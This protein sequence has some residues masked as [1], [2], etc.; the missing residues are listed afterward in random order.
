MK[1]SGLHC[2]GCGH[3]GGKR[4]AGAGA[5]LALVVLA[6]IAAHRRTIG[7]AASQAM[8][9]LEVAAEVTAGLAVAAGI[10]A[11]V[12]VTRRRAARRSAVSAARGRAE[13]PPSVRIL[14]LPRRALAELPAPGPSG[15]YALAAHH[16]EQ[17][18]SPVVVPAPAQVANPPDQAH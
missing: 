13:I 18:A 1:C 10:T 4:G 14:G 5:V 3:H 9:V 7:H 17:D 15:P 6:V 12:L 2:P 16:A 11:A 8:R